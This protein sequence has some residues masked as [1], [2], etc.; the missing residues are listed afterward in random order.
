MNWVAKAVK[1]YDIW[2]YDGVCVFVRE[3]VAEWSNIIQYYCI[4][5]TLGVVIIVI[6]SIILIAIVYKIQKNIAKEVNDIE[7]VWIELEK[8]HDRI[9]SL[10]GER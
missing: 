5:F 7:E 3:K 9:E 8:A 4:E 6:L 10:E 1:N 2:F